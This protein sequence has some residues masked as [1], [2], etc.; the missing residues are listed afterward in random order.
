MGKNTNRTMPSEQEQM[1]ALL[2]G[3][4]G[5]GGEQFNPNQEAFF[6]FLR[7]NYK[8]DGA[9]AGPGGIQDLDAEM[10]GGDIDM[11]GVQIP[12]AAKK[13]FEEAMKSK[14]G[15]AAPVVVKGQSVLC[16]KTWD[17]DGKKIFFNLGKSKKV[18][19]PE[20]VLKDGEEQTRLPMSLGAP[21]EDVDA[22]GEACLVFDVLFHPVTLEDA[23]D[24][25][26]LKFIVEM[27]IMRAEEKHEDLPR[28]NSERK[29]KKLKQKNF[30]GRLMSD[31]M[32]APQPLMRGVDE[33]SGLRDFSG[34]ALAEPVFAVTTP[35]RKADGSQVVRLRVELP[36]VEPSEL[37]VRVKSDSCSVLVPGKYKSLIPVAR[38]MGY[39]LLSS[40]FHEDNHTLTL[41]WG[42]QHAKE[43]DEE[44]REKRV[45]EI[46]KLEEESRIQLTNDLA[47]NLVTDDY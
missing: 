19:A 14:E 15:Q 8:G 37:E 36:G 26:F 23:T 1:E 45:A 35:K 20:L 10:A 22:K 3:M 29:W 46:Q 9:A 30:K 31:Q 13:I 44:Q 12:E 2:S 38:E 27:C 17:V 47:F 11:D 24:Y 32:L 28:F 25:M 21:F 7:E 18:D 42:P 39:T 5:E 33:E 16:I 4:S 6:N 43:F 40:R 41:V 34:P